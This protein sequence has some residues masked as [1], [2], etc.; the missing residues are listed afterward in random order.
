MDSK[1]ARI[2]RT[3]PRPVGEAR[4]AA[5]AQRIPRR[6]RLTAALIAVLSALGFVGWLLAR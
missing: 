5:P 4:S 6:Y 2:G 3:Y 1:Y